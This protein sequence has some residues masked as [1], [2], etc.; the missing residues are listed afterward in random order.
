MALLYFSIS[1]T[2]KFFSVKKFITINNRTIE[3]NEN[4][5]NRIFF[6]SWKK[7]QKVKIIDRNIVVDGLMKKLHTIDNII[8]K[9][10]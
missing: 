10:E 9:D 2:K 7:N 6:L 3:N 1:S 4:M 8:K 5:R